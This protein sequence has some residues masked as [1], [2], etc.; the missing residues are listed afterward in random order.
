MINNYPTGEEE[1]ALE[2]ALNEL[3][4]RRQMHHRNALIFYRA[5]IVGLVIASVALGIPIG[6]QIK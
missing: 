2:E 5:Q 4:A 1:Q 3:V 6:L